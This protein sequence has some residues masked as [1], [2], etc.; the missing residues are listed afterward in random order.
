MLHHQEENLVLL[1]DALL[2]CVVAVSLMNVAVILPSF[3]SF[4]IT[5]NTSNEFTKT[6]SQ[7]V[8][9]FAIES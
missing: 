9:G 2:L 6:P 3:V 1:K 8:M 7:F 4:S 5:P